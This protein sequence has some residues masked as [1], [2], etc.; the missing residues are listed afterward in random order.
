MGPRARDWTQGLSPALRDALVALNALARR[1][2]ALCTSE[3]PF[4]REVEATTDRLAALQD[5]R[6]LLGMPEMGREHLMVTLCHVAAG[7]CAS[8]GGEGKKLPKCVDR[9]L[10]LIARSV[11][12]PPRLEFTE[13]VLAN[14]CPARDMRSVAAS[15]SSRPPA[16]DGRPSLSSPLGPLRVA[17]R[18]LACPDEEWYRA[19]HIVLHEQARDLV[20]AIRVGQVAICDQNDLGVVGSLESISAWLNKFCDFFDGQFENKDSRTESVTFMRMEPFISHSSSNDLTLEETACWVYMSGSS[21]ILPA[22]HAFLGVRFCAVRAPASPEADRL[23]EHLQ[24]LVEECRTLMPRLHRVFVEELEKPGA[25]LR[26]YSF[27]RFGN[28][29]ASVEQMH[30][31]E[32]AYNDALNALV[33]YLSRRVHLVSRAFPALAV[34]FGIYHGE[35]EAFMRR[36]RLELLK[37]R[38]RAH[39]CLE[40]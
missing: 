24:H 34:H 19:V 2:P 32:V 40:R 4:R 20:S 39:R 31:L 33:R 26:Q 35:I 29:S 25:S 18:F 21:P 37:M 5:D 13:L 36:S 16:A 11:G 10:Q 9:P 38:R 7:C 8:Q 22:V 6:L 28:T 1:L 12:R 27:Q 14:W 23:A 3:G 15:S 17:W 30:D